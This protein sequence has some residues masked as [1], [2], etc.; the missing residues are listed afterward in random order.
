M[1][2][3]AGSISSEVRIKLSALN[4]D[5]QS[6][7]TAFDNLGTEFI[8]LAEKYS[9]LAGK[10][11][12]NSLKTIATEI[13]NVE[14][15]QKAGA[16]SE[17]QSTQRL[18][19]LRKTELAILQNKAVK[20]GTASSETVAAIK[21]TETALGDLIEKEKLLSSSGTTGGSFMATF[22][23]IRD[24][25]MGPIAAVKEIVA[26]FQNLKAKVDELEGAWGEQEDALAKLNSIIKTTGAD[27]WTSMEHLT[28]MASSL[29]K[30]T[31]YGDETIESM[32]GVLLGFRNITGTNFDEATKAALDMATVMK[33]D[34]T[35]AAQ[36]V[37]KALDQP[38]T[39]LDSLAR[40]G[41]K[42]TTQGK[43]MMQ[44]MVDAGNTAGAQKIILDE[45]NKTYGGTSEAVAETA[46]GLKVR[47]KNAMSDVNEEIG[48]SISTSLVPFR[49]RWLKIAE[50]IGA[51]VKAQNDFRDAMD[52]TEKGTATADE[53]LIALYGE[54]N[55]LKKL[56]GQSFGVAGA[57]EAYQKEIDATISLINAKK[58]EL[59]YSKMSTE[60][61]KKAAEAKVAQSKKQDSIDKA[62]NEAIEKYAEDLASIAIQ[63]KSGSLDAEK[64][65]QERLEARQTEVNALSDVVTKNKLLTGITVDLLNSEVAALKIETVAI[66]NEKTAIELA[67]KAKT[68]SRDTNAAN[69]KQY[70][71]IDHSIIAL[72]MDIDKQ[73]LALSAKSKTETE[74]LEEARKKLLEQAATY[75]SLGFNVDELIAK[76][77]K[78][79]DDMENPKAIKKLVTAM[80]AV[81]GSIESI[82]SSISTIITSSYSSQLSALE[83][84][85]NTELELIEYNGKTKQEYLEAE[86]A[87]Y[88]A[89]G[90]TESAA[91]AQKALDEYNLEVAYNK[92]KT[93]LQYES[94]LSAWELNVL[95]AT[96]IGA[97]AVIKAWATDPTGIL[98]NILTTAAVG[99]QIVAVVAAKPTA[100]SAA[101]GGIVLP[102]DGGS[103]VNVAENKSAELLLNNSNSGSA[104]IEAFAEKIVAA[105]GSIG[106]SVSVPFVVDGKQLAIAI[107]RYVNNGQVVIK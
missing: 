40:Q 81:S 17:E 11:Y 36:V 92:K 97:L 15:A 6:C 35:S 95:S 85:Y 86:L 50:S 2:V 42:F 77:N 27:S 103:L 79:Y 80:E 76:I 41:F 56:Q 96:A 54:Y 7:K 1:G 99:A 91:D 102:S 101:T 72:T 45:L 73:Q 23:A 89:A 106:G 52:K 47:L 25:M 59:G 75:A 48:R 49:E 107:I 62:R 93:Q 32:Q 24:V 67:N 61:A 84:I 55:N 104:M 71:D 74:G 82:I 26:V 8:D 29:Q 44:S 28:D 58:S 19:D 100:P 9:T 53:E 39:G 37:G 21:K 14:S 5:I 22:A 20:E 34:L 16:L 60:Q 69:I 12:T 63:E 13:K 65:S 94:D 90:D 43:A 4:A 51:A 30:V 57:Y 87:S 64:A 83:E 88:L 66:D 78:L 18:I 38:A 33:M 98:A 105:M 70:N 68:D 10:K 46:T 3:D 31:I